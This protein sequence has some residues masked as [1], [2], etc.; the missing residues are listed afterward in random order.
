MKPPRPRELTKPGDRTAVDPQEVQL[1]HDE[2]VSTITALLT[3]GVCHNGVLIED[4]TAVGGT[5]MRQ[6]HGLGRVPKFVLVVKSSGTWITVFVASTLEVD[7][8][9]HVRFTPSG[10]GTIS[11]LV[12]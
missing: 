3:G 2:V 10:S 12:A 5:E 1:G 6:F 8:R 9:N 11:V 4:L 7:P